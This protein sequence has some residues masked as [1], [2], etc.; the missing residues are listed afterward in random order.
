MGWSSFRK[1]GLT[2]HH[3]ARSWKGYTLVTVIFGD[4]TYLLDMDGQIVH[5]WYFPDLR[6]FYARLLPNGN[7]LALG[8]HPDVMPTISPVE[9]RVL[10][11]NQRARTMG[12][13]GSQLVEFNWEGERVW[14]YNNERIHH[15][16]VRLANGNTIMPEWVEMP[17]DAD[18]LVQGGLREPR[19]RRPKL[20][21]DDFIEIDP[22]GKEMRRVTRGSCLTL[23]VTPSAFWKTGTNGPI[24]TASTL[25]WQTIS[26]SSPAATTAEWA[27]S[28]GQAGACNGSSARQRC[29]TSI[30]H[31]GWPTATYR[32]SIT[33][34]TAM[35]CHTLEWLRSTPRTAASLGSTPPNPSS[36]SLVATSPGR[37]GSPTVTCLS[38]RV[39]V[40]G[41]LKSRNKGRLPGSG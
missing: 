3:S 36:S 20:V 29:S 12:G 23:D 6:V 8:N 15:D 7:L 2:H 35:G 16:F 31:P 38:V 11:I 9:G 5:R 32:S 22:T 17:D 13:N 28:I 33:A 40:V 37:S 26:C 24:P 4:A 21:S 18:R 10:P 34:C 1:P 14:S 41:S 39:L 30:T 25:T 27:S 19:S